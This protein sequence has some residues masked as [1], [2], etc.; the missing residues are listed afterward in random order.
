MKNT[1]LIILVELNGMIMVMKFHQLRLGCV[2]VMAK[3]THELRVGWFTLC[4]TVIQQDYYF[5][6][7]MN[8]Y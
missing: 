5:L 7:L 1:I 3:E 4:Y 2:L 6:V 8:L